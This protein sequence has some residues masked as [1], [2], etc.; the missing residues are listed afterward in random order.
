MVETIPAV[1]P[2]IRELKNTVGKK[3]NQTNGLKTSQKYHCI[4][5][6]INGSSRAIAI[7]ILLFSRISTSALS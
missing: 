1:L 5:Q 6:V 4:Q 2:P 3:R 7:F